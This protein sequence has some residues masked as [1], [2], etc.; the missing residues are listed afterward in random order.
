[1]ETKKARAN[2]FVKKKMSAATIQLKYLYKFLFRLWFGGTGWKNEFFQNR[3]FDIHK[4]S[5]ERKRGE[6]DGWQLLLF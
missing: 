6:Y 1:M 3:L 4:H 2:G 5:E